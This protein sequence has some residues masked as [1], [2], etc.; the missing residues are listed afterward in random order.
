M[1]FL[2]FEGN[3]WCF[4]RVLPLEDQAPVWDKHHSRKEGFMRIIRASEHKPM[5]WKNGGGTATAIVES[6]DGAG[7]DAF[8]WRISGA[9]VGRDGPFSVFPDVDRTMFILRGKELCLH[10]LVPDPVRLRV[11]SAPFDFPGDV[12][13]SA[14]LTSGSVDDLNIMVDRRR[15][16]RAARRLA[17][18]SDARIEPRGVLL[19]YAEYGEI[20][21][22][23]AT[24]QATLHTNDTLV[25]EE[26]ADITVAEDSQ[27]IL[28]D[29]W[30]I[31][32]PA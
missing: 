26:T 13:V 25:C 27:A 31:K 8:D 19:V 28:I 17:V 24:D 10:G 6:P 9:H 3:H 29:I 4:L 20:R 12:P 21:V 32:Q 15:F 7:F 11:T 30:P 2:S 16:Q 5:P 23:T 22:R 1:F 18:G 14:T